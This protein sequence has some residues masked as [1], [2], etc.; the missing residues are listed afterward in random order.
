[1][2]DSYRS[3]FRHPS[4]D[5]VA[6]REEKG[7]VKDGCDAGIDAVKLCVR[8]PAKKAVTVRNILRRPGTRN[9]DF[10]IFKNFPITE[11]VKAQFRTEFYNLTNITKGAPAVTLTTSVT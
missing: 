2:E 5:D 3:A 11:R 7:K 10:S 4:Q 6:Q 9:M 8:P 1:M